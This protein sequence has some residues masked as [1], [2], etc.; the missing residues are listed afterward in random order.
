[1]CAGRGGLSEGDWRAMTPS[2]IQIA[3]KPIVAWM[4]EIKDR[5]CV[6]FAPTKAK[7]Q[8]I[9]TSSYWEAYGK[10]GWPRAKAW[11]AEAYDKSWLRNEP[12]RAFCE[13]YVMDCL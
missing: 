3:T 2:E 12:P 10:N 13:S 11:R 5:T 6:V 4:V 7:A 9:A 1:M 8:W